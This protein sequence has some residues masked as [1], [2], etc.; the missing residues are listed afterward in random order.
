MFEKDI[1]LTLNE[2]L[3]KAEKPTSIHFSQV[4][5]LQTG[6]ILALFPEKRDVIEL[7]KSCINVLI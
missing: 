7:L 2:A 3:Q 6:A 4:S 5:Y 1:M